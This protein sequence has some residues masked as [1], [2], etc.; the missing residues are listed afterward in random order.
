[1]MISAVGV[2]ERCQCLYKNQ[3]IPLASRLRLSGRPASHGDCRGGPGPLR[4]GSGSDGHVNVTLGVHNTISKVTA[5]ARATYAIRKSFQ[6]LLWK[7]KSI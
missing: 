3:I 1:M 2:A 7:C 5:A 4:H 6:E